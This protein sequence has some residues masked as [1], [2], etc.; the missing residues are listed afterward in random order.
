MLQ[1]IED[2]SYGDDALSPLIPVKE[3]FHDPA[4]YDDVDFKCTECKLKVHL[5]FKVTPKRCLELGTLF[6]ATVLLLL[7]E[8]IDCY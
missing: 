2:R 8:L 3:C 1:L 6:A 4:N 7:V 5:N